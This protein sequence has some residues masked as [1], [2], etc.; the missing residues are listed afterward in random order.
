MKKVIDYKTAQANLQA[1]KKGLKTARS[2]VIELQNAETPDDEKIKKAESTVKAFETKVENAEK[3]VNDYKP[4]FFRRTSTY[5]GI[6]AA[7]V[8]TGGVV[9]YFIFGRKPNDS[10]VES[11]DGNG[12]KI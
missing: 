10:T 11:E 7:T 4:G 8:L 2:N 3:L 5:I 9:L 1:V 12:D 6:G